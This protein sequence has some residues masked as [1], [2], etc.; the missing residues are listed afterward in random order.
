MKN[1]TF[2]VVSNDNIKMYMSKDAAKNNPDKPAAVSFPIA[3]GIQVKQYDAANDQ[4]NVTNIVG[5]VVTGQ[6]VEKGNT[7]NGVSL[8][9]P[10]AGT[11]TKPGTGTN[12]GTG[13]GTGSDTGHGGAVS[14]T[15]KDVNTCGVAQDG[16]LKDVA[17]SMKDFFANFTTVIQMPQV[18]TPN[19][20]TFQSKFQSFQQAVTATPFV[21]ATAGFFKV[22]IG[23]GACP[24]YTIPAIQ[25]DGAGSLPPATIDQF[26]SQPAQN[27]FHVIYGV[28][29]VMCAFFAFRRAIE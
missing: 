2:S 21:N 13:T 28:W 15:C 20:D 14:I 26:C 16:T 1:G 5:G 24:T 29:C 9:V 8:G 7:T 25:I 18:Y 11:G 6:G 3:G 22:S 12:P 27:M 19:K 4:T 23:A 10:G 17:A